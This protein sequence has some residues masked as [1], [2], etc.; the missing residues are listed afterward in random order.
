MTSPAF[1]EYEASLDR[2]RLANS[3]IFPGLPRLPPGELPSDRPTVLDEAETKRI[4]VRRRLANSGAPRLR[5]ANGGAKG[6]RTRLRPRG[7]GPAMRHRARF[8]ERKPR[9]HPLTEA[10]LYKDGLLP[11]RPDLA[12][13]QEHLQCS[14]CLNVKSHPVVYSCGHSDCYACVRQ[15]FECYFTCPLC[16]ERITSPPHADLAEED[17]IEQAFPEWIDDSEVTYSWAGLIFPKA[18]A[19]I[20]TS[21]DEA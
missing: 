18:F 4:L 7:S 9:D 11:S 17:A 19:P 12:S 13:H 16:S 15:W 2:N 21:E 6:V 20:D 1:L 5:L 3:G 8:G 10:E 14:L